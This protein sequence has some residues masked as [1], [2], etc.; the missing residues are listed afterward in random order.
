V[1]GP[2]Q[3]SFRNAWSSSS[4]NSSTVRGTVSAAAGSAHKR[5]CQLQLQVPQFHRQQQQRHAATAGVVNPSAN[6]AVPCSD[7]HEQQRQSL[8]SRL[9]ALQQRQHATPGASR[10]GHGSS[11][12]SMTC[13]TC[14]PRC[15]ARWF[16]LAT[17]LPALNPAQP[18]AGLGFAGA[19]DSR[20]PEH[21]G[22]KPVAQGLLTGT[23]LSHWGS[24]A[25]VG[26]TRVSGRTVCCA[27]VTQQQQQHESSDDVPWVNNA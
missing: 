7:W 4:S 3:V 16:K 2:S 10:A 27:Q 5:R 12:S 19:L 26:R 14:D 17:S 11:S 15:P 24:M 23:D 21:P 8:L 20:L 22:F 25:G 18:S 13:R 9:R 6:A 1:A